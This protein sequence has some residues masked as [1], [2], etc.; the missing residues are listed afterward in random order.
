MVIVCRGGLYRSQQ[1]KL[2]LFQILRQ[3]P[4]TSQHTVNLHNLVSIVDAIEHQI[5]VNDQP[6]ISRV[7]AADPDTQWEDH[8]S[9]WET[10]SKQYD[11]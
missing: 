7:K 2:N 3:I 11:V 4:S 8:E 10:L 9:V 1:S 5:L 6:T